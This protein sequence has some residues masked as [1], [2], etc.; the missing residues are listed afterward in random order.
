MQ[1]LPTIC[2][3]MPARAWPSW[4]ARRRW[5]RC[6]RWA[7]ARASCPSC[8]AICWARWRRKQRRLRRWMP[9]P[10]LPERSRVLIDS[11]AHLDFDEYGA[12]RAEVIARAK[13][14][15][16]EHIVLIGQWRAGFAQAREALAL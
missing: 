11:H 6:G 16:V 7:P 10:L 2:A 1:R 3:W 12:D 9:P 13:E 8:A 5:R 15:G 4:A 14:A